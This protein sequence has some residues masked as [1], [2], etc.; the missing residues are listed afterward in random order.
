MA[1][2]HVADPGVIER[3]VGREVGA[4]GEAEYDVHTL[5]FKA[6]H[7]GID[8][9]HCADLLSAIRMTDIPGIGTCPEPVISALN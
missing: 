4:A 3:V 6:F 1:H 5:G 2:Q 8:C 7:H 9:T